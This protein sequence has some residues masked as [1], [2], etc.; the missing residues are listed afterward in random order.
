MT[1]QTLT[2]P[3]RFLRDTGQALFS[4]LFNFTG[5][6]AGGVVAYNL[7]IF[8]TIPWALL[9]Y[10]GILSIRGAIGGLYAGRLSTALHL[11]T[12]K[13]RIFKNTNRII[14]PS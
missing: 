14:C 1:T 13:P 3:K 5:L 4:L 12:I 2:K 6:V 10:P 11:G 7:G 9:I 8:D